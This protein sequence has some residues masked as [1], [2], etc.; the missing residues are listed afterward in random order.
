MRILHEHEVNSNISLLYKAWSE[1]P[2]FAL[3][4]DKS[5]LPA[6]WIKNA[7]RKLPEEL[8]EGHFALLSSASTGMPKI[9]AG[10]RTR[11]EHLARTLH[12]VQES[13]KAD[14]TIAVLPLSYCYSFVNQWLWARVFE[15]EL[16]LT[17]GFRTPEMLEEK[18]MDAKNAMLCLVGAQLMLFM[19][20]FAGKSFPGI[21][22]LHFAGGMFPHE[23]MNEIK[24]FFPNALIFNNY[25]CVEAMPRLSIRREEDSA[26][27]HN[28]GRPLEGVEL[29]SGTDSELL[30][31]SPYG[32]VAFVDEKG[33][34]Q[35]SP[36]EWVSTGDLAR[37]GEDGTWHIVGR[38]G[39]V[40]KRYGEKIAVPQLLKVLKDSWKGHI[41]FY[42]EID[43]AGENGFV[44]VLAP[45]PKESEVRG[46]LRVFRS[47]FKR[48]HWPLRIE[49]TEVMPTLPSGKVDTIALAELDNKKLHWRQRS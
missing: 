22:R 43:S 38:K 9:V 5:G 47:G 39:E 18:L 28:I 10:S 48:P 37:L 15:R 1:P 6:G 13:S 46:I 29:K 30:F 24:N 32:A 8:R 16:I 44:L 20:H 27:P 35:I 31:R 36:E 19:R 11:A 17:S 21:I 34:H 45:E 14:Q 26:D 41:A 33:F 49:S 25:G 23:H 3:V 42:R 4:P 2:T 40:F 7:L 12:K